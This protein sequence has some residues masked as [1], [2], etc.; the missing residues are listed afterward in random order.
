MYMKLGNGSKFF[1]AN[2]TTAQ[3]DPADAMMQQVDYVQKQFGGKT[4]QDIA[5]AML[6]TNTTDK[7]KIRDTVGTG[8]GGIYDQLEGITQQ[9]QNLQRQK[10]GDQSKIFSAVG[11]D[12]KPIDPRVAV[13]QFQASQKALTDNETIL[14]SMQDMYNAQLDSLTTSEYNKQVAIN[15]KNKVALGYLKDTEDRELANKKLEQ[16]NSQFAERMA[17]DREQLAETKRNNNLDA[18]IT[19]PSDSI[20]V[21]VPDIQS[22]VTK[23]RGTDLVQC[24]MVSNDY[25]KMKTGKSMGIGNS[26]ESKVKA[27]ENAGKSAT[28]VEG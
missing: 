20:E 17:L 18:G 21:A 22:F 6:Q 25:W 10:A 9:I 12:G 15:D 24:G 26:Y 23:S 13:A 16:D 11:P 1:G 3:G 5:G 2:P 19:S 7:Q 4:Y 28:P 27:I 8:P 14:R